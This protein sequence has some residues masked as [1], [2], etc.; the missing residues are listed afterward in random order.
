MLQQYLS[1]PYVHALSLCSLLILHAST[2]RP[3][4]FLHVPWRHTFNLHYT[5]AYHVY[6]MRNPCPLTSS[7][8]LTPSRLFPILLDPK[9][10]QTT[11][12]SVTWL[13]G[14]VPLSY[15]FVRCRL[16]IIILIY[17]RLTLTLAKVCPHTCLITVRGWLSRGS[18]RGFSRNIDRGHKVSPLYL[19]IVS[20]NSSWL[21]VHPY[22]V[23]SRHSW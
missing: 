4:Y 3:P 15:P 1:G 18:H 9:S 2:L 6:T 13:P 10:F 5:C 19:R 21:N 23:C 12:D 16:I 8:T 7:L 20:R 11:L 17:V 14:H 22:V